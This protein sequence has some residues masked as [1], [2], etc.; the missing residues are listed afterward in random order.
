MLDIII[1][2]AAGILLGIGGTIGIK[3]IKKPEPPPVIIVEDETAEKQQ[4]V[5]LQLTDL[6]VAVKIC[7]DPNNSKLCRELLC[8]QF[9][10]GLGSQTSQ[11]QCE[12]ISNIHNTIIIHEY[13]KEQENYDDCIDLFWR[14][15]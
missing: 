1:A 12:S 6:D 10:K 5:V 11:S 7:E 8:Y 3:K 14:R 13:C 4:E 9:G 2:G 15:K